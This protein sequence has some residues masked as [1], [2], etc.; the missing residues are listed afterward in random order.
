MIYFFL[1]SITGRIV[2][3]LYSIDEHTERAERLMDV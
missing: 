3:T 1:G 2:V